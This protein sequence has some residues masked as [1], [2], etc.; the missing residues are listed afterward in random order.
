MIL[1]ASMSHPEYIHKDKDVCQE[2]E[3]SERIQRF[4]YLVFFRPKCICFAKHCIH[5][6]TTQKGSRIM[7]ESHKFNTISYFSPRYYFHVNYSPQWIVIT[8]ILFNLLD[9]LYRPISHKKN[10]RT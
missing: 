6:K 5:N 1:L 4:I 8:I 2:D 9:M 10:I 7:G 3:G